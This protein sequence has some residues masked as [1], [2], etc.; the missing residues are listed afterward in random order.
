MAW[1]EAKQ[2]VEA[3]QKFDESSSSLSREMISL[4]KRIYWLTWFIA[5]LTVTVVLL[6]AWLAFVAKPSFN[7]ASPMQEK[8]SHTLSNPHIKHEN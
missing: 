8:R 5:I 2:I 7:K 1:D 6:T 4:S 3:I